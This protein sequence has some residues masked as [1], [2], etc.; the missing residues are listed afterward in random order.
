MSFFKAFF[1]VCIIKNQ[2]PHITNE[3]LLAAGSF[4][5]SAVAPTGLTSLSAPALVQFQLGLF[6]E[7]VRV[8]ASNL[9]YRHAKRLAAE[10]IERKVMKNLTAGGWPCLTQLA[11]EERHCTYEV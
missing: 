6:R 1:C 8:P 5:M 10:I 2:H 3:S 7:E 9:S 4:S 11:H